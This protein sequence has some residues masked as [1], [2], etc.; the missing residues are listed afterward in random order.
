MTRY[1]SQGIGPVDGFP[2]PEKLTAKVVSPDES[3]ICGYD[4]V[5]DLAVHWSF[6]DM[7]YLAA[8]GELPADERVSTVIAYVLANLAPVSIAKAPAHA[9]HLVR[10]CDGTHA[11]TSA[12]AFMV[13]G[14]EARY[15]VEAHAPLF[16]WLDAS[17]NG[18]APV[19]DTPSRDA[20]A[21]PALLAGLAARGLA[22]ALSPSLPRESVLLAALWSLG[23]RDS[24]ALEA[25]WTFARGP[26][27]FAEGM[28]AVPRDFKSYPMGTPAFKYAYEEDPSP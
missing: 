1:G 27:A 13:A 18:E 7:L 8:C 4:V 5:N 23:V 17:S 16:A 24:H 9:A 22:L 6:S 15:T 26:F 20:R 19:V 25:L 21:T 12:A 11:A 10:L 14:E 3:R 2:W 28:R